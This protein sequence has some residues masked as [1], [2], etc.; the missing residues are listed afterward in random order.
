MVRRFF[1]TLAMLAA[2]AGMAHA[3]ESTAELRARIGRL[4]SEISGLASV[5]T[6]VEGRPGEAWVLWHL[7]WLHEQRGE[8]HFHLYAILNPPANENG[9]L[10]T[11]VL[12]PPETLADRQAYED[13]CRRLITRFARTTPGVEAAL[14]LGITRERDFQMDEAGALFKK[15]LEL[16]RNPRQVALARFFR[17]RW[18]TYQASRGKAPGGYARALEVIRPVAAGTSRLTSRDP[19]SSGPLDVRRQAL[20]LVGECLGHTGRPG[21]LEAALK[22]G[23]LDAAARVR[24]LEDL[25][26]SYVC[27]RQLPFSRAAYRILLAEHPKHKSARFW[28]ERLAH[29]EAEIAAGRTGGCHYDFCAS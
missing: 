3:E 6:K 9:D 7:A 26:H 27:W 14:D 22:G 28:R 25:A 23:G 29:V 20:W 12:P 1:L 19:Y 21:Q 13:L 15:A 4:D 8:A 5:V 18:L 11:G 16:A 17:A 10:V 2:M 24:L